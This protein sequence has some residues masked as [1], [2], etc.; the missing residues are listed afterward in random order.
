MMSA[1]REDVDVIRENAKSL[2]PSSEK[3]NELMED[4]WPL[5]EE[6]ET[7]DLLSKALLVAGP[8][9]LIVGVVLFLRSR[10]KS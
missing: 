6:L 7:L 3:Y 10:K 9:M 2:S 4:T 5:L 1:I 8:L